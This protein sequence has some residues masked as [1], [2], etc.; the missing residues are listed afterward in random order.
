MVGRSIASIFDF[1]GIFTGKYGAS[2]QYIGYRPPYHTV[3]Y[4]HIVTLLLSSINQPMQTFLSTEPLEEYDRAGGQG[5]CWA[6]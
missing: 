3:Y 5:P 4:T 6:I 2:V 1:S